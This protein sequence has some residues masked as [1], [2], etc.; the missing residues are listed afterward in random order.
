VVE[1]GILILDENA[2]SGRAL[3]DLLDSE[4]WR[5]QFLTD[6]REALS[7][8]ATGTW[9]L[10]IANVELARPGGH[11]FGLLRDLAHAEGV[12]VAEE[13]VRE[14]RTSAKKSAAEFPS[15]RK[16]RLRVLFIVPG[17]IATEVVPDLEREE[18]P[19]TIRPYHLH[20]FFEKISDLL[21][22]SGAISGP[23]PASRFE[24]GG[25]GR[26]RFHKTSEVAK[27]PT[28]F[29]SRRDYQMT[30]EEIAEY[31]RVE[32]EDRRKKSKKSEE[33]GKW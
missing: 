29:A 20:D 8:L 17:G 32:E 2:D 18:L 28:M 19:Y 3:H 14:T 12:T 15:V 31:E 11:L 13:T 10:V 33:E 22:E 1:I 24:M 21:V 5:V 16:K 27:I 9:N 7:S 23:S 26:S 6:S 25:P 4:G 30:E